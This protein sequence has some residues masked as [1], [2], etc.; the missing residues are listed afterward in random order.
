MKL[1]VLAAVGLSLTMA[2]NTALAADKDDAATQLSTDKAKVSYSIGVSIGENFKLQNIDVD[3]TLVAKG[4]NDILV[5]DKL[6]MK[7]KEM[8]TTMVNF[9]KQMMAKRQGEL[10]KVGEKNAK[11]GDAF[12]KTNKAK[13]GVVTLPSGLQYQVVTKGNGESPSANDL[14]TVDYE[15]KLVNGTVFDSS[16]KRGKPVTFQVSQVIPGWTE[17]LQKMKVGAT[18]HVFIPAKLAYG[19]NGVGNMIGP[20]QTLIFKIHLIKV[21]ASKNS[22]QSSK[23]QSTHTS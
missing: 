3:P 11:E 4:M 16:Y 5:G 7:K 8:E 1:P 2:L 10:K 21:Q 22:A 6:L 12:L 18:W 14:V 15:G 13:A 23:K 17:A 19:S 9:Q 20:N